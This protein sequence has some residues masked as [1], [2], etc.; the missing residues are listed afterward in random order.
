MRNT[1]AVIIV[2]LIVEVFFSAI[3][4]TILSSIV[5]EDVFVNKLFMPNMIHAG[6]IFIIFQLLITIVFF[7]VTTRI[8]LDF[9]PFKNII[10]LRS[11]DLLVGFIIGMFLLTVINAAL[12]LFEIQSIQFNSHSYGY[13][14]IGLPLTLLFAIKEEIVFRGFMLNYL[15]RKS[16]RPMAIL[17]SS[18]VFSLYHLGIKDFDFFAFLSIL[19]VGFILGFAYYKKR[20]IWFP[21]GIHFGWNYFLFFIY[22]VDGDIET[23]PLLL[24]NIL[25]VS[26]WIDWFELVF[27]T[28]V[29][30]VFYRLYNNHVFKNIDFSKF[31][32]I[33]KLNNR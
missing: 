26:V 24:G 32:Q 4:L 23:M 30:V 22:G 1:I 16:G 12:I 2:Y 5:Q 27:L 15:E 11:F 28:I 6:I 31:K 20:N 8:F 21:V 18:L 7:V 17:I 33:K 29:C 13:M 25:S 9:N 10:R 3:A 19:I 14:A